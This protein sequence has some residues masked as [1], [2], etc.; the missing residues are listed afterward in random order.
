MA[1]NS[2]QTVA[3]L[4]NYNYFLGENP[5][6]HILVHSQSF[7]GRVQKSNKMCVVCSA[8]DIVQIA[9]IHFCRTRKTYNAKKKGGIGYNIF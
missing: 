7:Q 2:R 3:T 4:P 5:E 8:A 1:D 6:P 9:Y